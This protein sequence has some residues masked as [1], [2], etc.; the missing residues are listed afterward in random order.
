MTDLVAKQA[1]EANQKDLHTTVSVLVESTSKRDNRVMVG[2]SEKN[3]TVHF[4]LPEGH[5]SDD[6]I[7]KIVNVYVEKA[8]TWYLKG[9]LQ[10]EP[11]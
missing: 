7:G 8:R 6:Y 9:T 4:V 11:R 2:H 5:V 10:G 1:F 3:Q